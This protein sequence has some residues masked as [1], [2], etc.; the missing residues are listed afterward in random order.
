MGNNI[1]VVSASVDYFYW[2]RK[3]ISLS[4]IGLLQ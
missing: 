4:L 1:K 2:E 3:E